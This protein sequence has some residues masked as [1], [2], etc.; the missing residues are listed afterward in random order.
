[1]PDLDEVRSESK[2]RRQKL[3]DFR[4]GCESGGQLDLDFSRLKELPERHV[5]AWLI[6]KYGVRVLYE[7]CCWDRELPASLTIAQRLGYMSMCKTRTAGSPGSPKS[8]CK[9]ERAINY[10]TAHA[11]SHIAR[12]N[13]LTAHAHSFT[14]HVCIAACWQAIP[15]TRTS[16]ALDDCQIGGT[17]STVDRGSLA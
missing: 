11:L 14:L 7:L 4:A 15:K 13:Y 10:L 3:H 8:P 6:L 5:E 1:M 9:K 12:V 2:G 17:W 16:V